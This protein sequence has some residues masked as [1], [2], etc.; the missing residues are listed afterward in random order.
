MSRLELLALA[1]LLFGVATASPL[2]AVPLRSAAFMLAVGAAAPGSAAP[3]EP[4]AAPPSPA[5]Q[6]LLEAVGPF[7]S[8]R[9][10]EAALEAADRALAAA[11]AAADLAG[12][13][14]AQ[15]ARGGAL[16]A[17]GRTEPA[18]AAWRAAAA[19]WERAGEGP[20][21][22]A[23][24]VRAALLLP[25]GALE[26]DGL[27]A[28]AVALGQNEKKRPRAAAR[29]LYGAG[30]SFYSQGRLR[31]A[32]LC[33]A[34]ALALFEKLLPDSVEAALGANGLGAVL[35][36][37]GDLAAAR[38]VFQRSLAI[39]QKLE[40]DSLDVADS[41]NNLGS[42]A[43]DQGDLAGAKAFHQR[44]LVIREK[45]S[46]GS[47]KVAH[48][49][50]N[51]GNVAYKEGSLAAAK[52]YHER[53]LAIREKLAPESLETAMS[54]TNLGLVARSQGDLTAARDYH[55]R[56]LALQEKLAPDS[57]SL[58]LT[59]NNLGSVVQAQGDLNA[60]REFHQ[61]SLVIREKLAPGSLAVAASL[62][63][64][65]STARE[66]GDLAAAR[67]YLERALA[68]REQRAPGSLDLAWSL[69]Y[70]GDMIVELG[71]LATARAYLQR[72]LEIR[73]QRAPHSLDMAASLAAMGSLAKQ[74]GDLVTARTYLLRSLA[75]KEKLAPGSLDV[76]VSLNSMGGVVWQQGDLAAAKTYHRRALAIQ[77]KLAPGSL[78]VA[79][80]LNSLGIVAM[81]QGDLTAAK[82]LYERALA[83]R[84]GR[85]PGSMDVAIT[86]NNLANLVREQ[87]DLEAAREYQLRAL[88]IQERLAP[89]SL[90]VAASFNNLGG[91][92]LDLGDRTG[93]KAYHKRALAIREK[94]SPGSLAVAASRSNLGHVAWQH[95]DRAAAKSYFRSALSMRERLAPHSRDVAMSLYELGT[96]VYQEGDR[97][98]AK[99]HWQSALTLQEQLAPGSLGVA[100]ILH[101]LGDLARRGGS[102]RESERYAAR[103]WQIVRRQAAAVSGDEARLAFGASHAAYAAALVRAQIALR[104]PGPAFR[105]L[106]E[107]RAQALLQ[108]MA[109]RHLDTRAAPRPLQTAYRA[110]I[111]ARDR[112]EQSV[113]EASIA[114]AL[115]RR[116]RERVRA[117]GAAGE[118]GAGTPGAPEE[119]ARKLEATRSAYVRARVE[120]ERTWERLKRSLPRA[121][122]PPVSPV[123]AARTL[124]PGML[125]IAYAVGDE[126]TH[127]FLLRGGGAGASSI[128]AQT[129]PIP[130]AALEARVAEFHLRVADS[131][132]PW[133]STGREL[134]Q[135]LFPPAARKAIQGARRLLISP[136]GA[137][138]D[139]PF[140]ALVTNLRGAPRCL[141]A[142]QPITYTQSLTLFAQARRDRPGRNRTARPR[143]LVI[144]DPVFV[145]A[146]SRLAAVPPGE[147]LAHGERA[148]LFGDIIPA[149]LPATRVEAAEIAQLYGGA[150]LLGERATEAELR[151]QIETADVIHLA[152][153]GYLHTAR[154]MSSG[155]LLTVPAHRGAAQ[156]ASETGPLATPLAHAEGRRVPG[157]AASA[158][159]RRAQIP[160]ERGIEASRDDGVL[161]AW[162]IYSQ[163]K[164]KAEL[165]VLS[166]CE[167]GRG[168]R[169][170]GEGIVGLARALQYAGARSVVV[171]GWQVAD[172]STRRLMVELHRRARQGPATA[173]SARGQ[174]QG[175]DEALRQA[176]AV[177]RREPRT[178]HP[179]YWAPFFLLGDP[180]PSWPVPR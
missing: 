75:L 8:A 106:E 63:S 118:T 135:T 27:V 113:S 2:E 49:L 129:I 139:V 36:A 117:T 101:G 25:V 17:Q 53:S 175:R 153:H 21:R 23:A 11:Q 125:L 91:I 179:Y 163:L 39:Y 134:F 64:L 92:S 31:E 132:A 60:A 57:L 164:L 16:E 145:R 81:E 51:L 170:R 69:Y 3:V 131:E 111:A 176:M 121:F 148:S 58:A 1:I 103:A 85:A 62:S 161:Q 105:T 109:Q 37:Q 79:F 47:I 107:G 7:V 160:V 52:E 88:A 154:P 18:E 165:V 33:S 171:S 12:E 19:T 168:E 157:P 48:S 122:V 151:R 102:I 144:G 133:V 180:D 172:E 55:R 5:V 66:Q 65:G 13:A 68:I 59:L 46:P 141:G 97:G 28:Q 61:G 44:S 142:Q 174:R 159:E 4:S 54:L 45:R 80:S 108:L 73:E 147:V 158:R 93:A 78:R 29:R 70:L 112:A 94:L 166:A 136:D 178:A 162:E 72:A 86:L 137:L 84:E 41:L 114:V 120:A 50:N 87:G 89:D 110:A 76:A 155:V 116:V 143:A 71:E 124:P 98:A 83:I 150:P 77:E 149:P 20:E 146:S 177:L 43:F 99:R 38:E 6:K 15:E 26:A 96:V 40:P 123:A 67:E 56:A 169:V 74:Q 104:Q 152:T 127:L 82:A 34:A 115:A 130:R 90:A 173:G 156:G 100:I 42:L 138:W 126:A 119:A 24:L 32:R 95:G 9:R 22:A 128:S 167:T 10:F 14:R 30:Y 140:A 35:L